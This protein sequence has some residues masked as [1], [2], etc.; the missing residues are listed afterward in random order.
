MLLDNTHCAFRP[1]L[2]FRDLKKRDK[3]ASSLFHAME[4]TCPGYTGDVNTSF[5]SNHNIQR[6]HRDEMEGAPTNEYDIC[7]HRC[8]IQCNLGD[9]APDDTKH[10]KLFFNGVTR[11]E[12]NWFAIFGTSRHTSVMFRASTTLVNLSGSRLVGIIGH[13][14]PF[15]F[16]FLRRWA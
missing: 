10:S 12:H 6:K 4:R 13:P 14:D 9:Y 5:D 3:C 11:A 7:S 15:F 8:A 2:Y 1:L 16:F